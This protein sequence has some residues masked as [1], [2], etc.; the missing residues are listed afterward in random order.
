MQH[1]LVAVFATVNQYNITTS[2]FFADL[3]LRN[4]RGNEQIKVVKMCSVVLLSF[5][6]ISV[7]MLHIILPFLPP[8]L[9]EVLLP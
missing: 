4:F 6:S 2:H 7:V 8:F 3:Q 1:A 5:L 9:L